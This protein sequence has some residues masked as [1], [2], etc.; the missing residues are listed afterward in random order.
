MYQPSG[1]GI[2]AD[3]AYGVVTLP[4]PK[5]KNRNKDKNK[6]KSKSKNKNKITNKNNDSNNGGGGLGGIWR[7]AK[8]PPDKRS[9][10]LDYEA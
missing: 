10:C 7:W 8:N 3:T 4:T 2:L 5:S 9:V 1:V 6:S